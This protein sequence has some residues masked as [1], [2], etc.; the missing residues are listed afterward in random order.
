MWQNESTD[1][2]VNF[3]GRFPDQSQRFSLGSRSPGRAGHLS[4]LFWRE[5]QRSAWE[6]IATGQ[7]PGDATID[8]WVIHWS[9]E[10]IIPWWLALSVLHTTQS[11][12]SDTLSSYPRLNEGPCGWGFELFL[13]P[14]SY[15]MQTQTQAPRRAAHRQTINS[16]APAAPSP[17]TIFTAITHSAVL[18]TRVTFSQRHFF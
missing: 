3:S 12:Q 1:V 11:K 13:Y 17:T 6:G 15:V 16:R 5:P 2:K 4:G 14:N 10:Y 7:R 18:Y 9:K 8:N